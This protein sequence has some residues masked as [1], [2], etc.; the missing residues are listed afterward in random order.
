[1]ERDG[2]RGNGEMERGIG[3]KRKDQEKIERK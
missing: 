1:M 3:E 2:E